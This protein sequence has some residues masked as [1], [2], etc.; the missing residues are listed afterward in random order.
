MRDAAPTVT[1][2]LRVPP[3]IKAQVQALADRL[4][5]TMTETIIHIIAEAARTEGIYQP[6]EETDQ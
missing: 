4:G 1:I 3:E 6:A 2:Y 5:L